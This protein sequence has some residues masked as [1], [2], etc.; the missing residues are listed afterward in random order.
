MLLLTQMD[1]T[2]CRKMMLN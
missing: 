2:F 1:N